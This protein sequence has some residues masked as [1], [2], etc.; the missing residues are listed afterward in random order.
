MVFFIKN[1]QRDRLKFLSKQSSDVLVD[2]CKLAL[3]YLGSGS[4][5][6][7]YSIA[8]QKLETTLEDVQTTVECLVSLLIDCAA[9]NVSESDF[10]EI[11]GV[12]FS[13]EQIGILWQFVSNKNEAVR[14]LLQNSRLNKQYRFRDLEWRLEARIASRSNLRQATPQITM[15]FHLDRETI[16]VH[17]DKIHETP[18]SS[19]TTRKQIILNTDPCNLSHMIST[20]ENALQ[21]SKTHRTRNFL[22]AFQQ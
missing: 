14:N 9:Y 12:G 2:F 16:N 1:S 4:N 11:S 20:L 15:K 10:G 17:K 7:K 8:A 18:E 19:K 21:Q 5:E 22:K 6:K 3:D 13:S